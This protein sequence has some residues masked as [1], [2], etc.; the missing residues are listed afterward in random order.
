MPIP[1]APL[2]PQSRR[3]SRHCLLPRLLCVAL[4][5]ALSP[6]AWAVPNI[7]HWQTPNGVRVLFVEAHE[8]PIVD[9]QVVFDAG[10][11]RDGGKPGVA[12]LTG[13]LLDE[14]TA[15]LTVDQIAERF[16][17]VGAQFSTSVD[18][19]SA[20][21]SLRS[22]TDPGLLKT[23]VETLTDVLQSPTFPKDSFERERKRMLVAL[24][25][26]EESPGDIANK[27]FYA[28]LY[29]KNPYATDPDGTPA[30]LKAMSRNDVADFYRHYY[31][32]GNALI[33]I[34]GDIDERQ[35]GKL[36]DALM[37]KLPQGQHAPPVPDAP[38]LDKSATVMV[39]HPSTQ[40]HVLSGQVGITRKDPDFFP[41]YVGNYILGG[42]GLV[43][44]L[45]EEIREK[46][47]LSYSTY[48]YF[49]PM[50]AKGPFIMGLQTRNNEVKQAIDV[51]NR[52]LQQ[53]V[54]DGPTAEELKEAKQNITGGFP[55]RIDSNQ[56]IAGYLAMIG[57]YDMPLD[58]LNTFNDHVDAVTL[59]D[60]RSAFSRHV[61]PDKRLTVIVG[62]GAETAAPQ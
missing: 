32:A 61:H 53:Y 14:G 13:S 21:V 27:R 33:V 3:H 52:T 12:S 2:R 43:S 1:I 6:A 25:Q 55:L 40:T 8:L 30:A 59:D 28:A 23:A 19:D 16:D 35:A 46:R 17:G 5:A 29:G 50:A 48:S 45:A 57:L 44:R 34:V 51:M 62:G 24:R 42:N 54:A 20:T 49:L 22:L 39:P 15:D 26:A 36:A 11:A 58:Y 56:K 31:V 9:I 10:S 41:L 47:G 37:D 38:P 7:Q 18:R 60:I 4:I